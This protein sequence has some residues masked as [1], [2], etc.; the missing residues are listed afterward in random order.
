M[1]NQAKSK[2]KELGQEDFH[3]ITALTEPQIVHFVPS[4]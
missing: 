4:G 3:Y 2:I 1:A